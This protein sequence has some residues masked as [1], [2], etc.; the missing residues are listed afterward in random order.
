MA[1][2]LNVRPGEGR[3]VALLV[4]LMLFTSAGGS[5]GGNGIEALFYARFGVQFLPYMYMALGVITLL[6][7]LT[8][9]ALLGRVARERL[10]LFLPAILALVLIGERVLLALNPSW[11]YPVLW[12]GMNVKGSLQGLLTWGL[13]GAVCDTRQAKRLFPLFGAGGILGAVVGGLVTQPLAKWL[14]S[15]N[16]LLVWAGAL[17]LAFLLNRAL[18]GRTPPARALSGRARKKTTR[19]IDEMQQGYQ[20]VRRSPLMRWMAAAAVLFSVLFFSLAL[21]FSRAATQQFPDADRLAGFLGLFQ[22]LSTGVAFLVSLFVA[23]RLFARFGIM[24]TIL[25]LP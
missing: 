11:I 3:I 20:F 2:A 5:I 7:S 10:Y 8:I 1:E 19:L 9:T 21:P 17:V 22:G 23:N 12:L 18:I 16:L 25:A 13:A 15:E 4:G 14:H 24:S 6:T